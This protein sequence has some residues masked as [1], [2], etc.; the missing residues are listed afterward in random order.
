MEE[1]ENVREALKRS[2]EINKSRLHTDGEP[3][4]AEDVQ[5]LN[6]EIVYQICDLLGCSDLY[7]ERV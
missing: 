3:A 7:L 5:E 1:F 4:T 6:L 2:I